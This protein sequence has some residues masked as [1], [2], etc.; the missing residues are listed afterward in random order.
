M[1]G[2]AVAIILI[3]SKKVPGN[4]QLVLFEAFSKEWLM[5]I[6]MKL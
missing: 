1:Y 5:W 3:R 4:R 6:A 2:A